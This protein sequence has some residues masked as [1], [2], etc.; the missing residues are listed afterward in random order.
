[1]CYH[2]AMELQKVLDEL[3]GLGWFDAA[4]AGFLGVAPLTVARWRT[5][6]FTPLA[7]GMVLLAARRLKQVTPPRKRTAWSGQAG[8][9]SDV[10][11][12]DGRAAVNKALEEVRALGWS[13]NS[14]ADAFGVSRQS[15]SAWRNGRGDPS[16]YSLILLAIEELKG[17]G[18]P[19]GRNR[20]RTRGVRR[21]RARQ[22]ELGNPTGSPSSLAN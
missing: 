20:A 4:L 11:S 6:R 15:V 16:S 9:D 2:L 17:E 10:G 8:H 22:S 7:P 1:M 19:S 18:P 14:L 13:D 5:G 21:P 12:E 3:H